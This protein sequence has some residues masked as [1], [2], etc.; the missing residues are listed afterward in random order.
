M[1]ELNTMVNEDTKRYYGGD[2]VNIDGEGQMYS[3][4]KKIGVS[5][6]CP[7]RNTVFRIKL[8]GVQSLCSYTVPLNNTLLPSVCIQA[9]ASGAKLM[10]Y[11]VIFL[12][13]LGAVVYIIIVLQLLDP[14]II[15]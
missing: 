3:V 10:M 6:G 12:Q 9:F 2:E 1:G 8:V 5:S 13:P 11:K 15:Q 14:W 4:D 7:W